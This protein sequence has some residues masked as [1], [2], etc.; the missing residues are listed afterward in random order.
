[1]LVEPAHY[2]GSGMEPFYKVGKLDPYTVVD[3]QVQSLMSGQEL[4]RIEQSLYQLV[5][6]GASKRLLDFTQ[7]QYLSSQAIGIVVALRSKTAKAPGG[8]LALCGVGT[9]LHQLLKITALDRIL[10]IYKTRKDALAAK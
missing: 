4:Q 2:F 5:D 9:Q 8:K 7:V 1:L 10:P 6:E 3:F